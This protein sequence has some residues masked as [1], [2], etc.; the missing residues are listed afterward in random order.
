MKSLTQNAFKAHEV[1]LLFC[2]PKVSDAAKLLCC[3]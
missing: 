2:V 1:L 3:D